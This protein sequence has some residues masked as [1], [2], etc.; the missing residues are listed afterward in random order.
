MTKIK[1]IDNCVYKGKKFLIDEKARDELLDMY[2]KYSS[3]VK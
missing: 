2:G 1:L 3:I